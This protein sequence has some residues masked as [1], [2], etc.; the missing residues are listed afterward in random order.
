M[1]LFALKFC[2]FAFT[3]GAFVFSAARTRAGLNVAPMTGLVLT[4]P[5]LFLAVLIARRFSAPIT[6]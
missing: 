5:G 6:M 2:P 1:N 4:L 3:T